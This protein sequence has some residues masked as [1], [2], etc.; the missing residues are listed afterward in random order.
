LSDRI[1][2]AMFRDR[3]AAEHAIATMRRAGVSDEAIAVL[4][5]DSE[6]L[7]RGEYSDDHR[8]DSKSSGA[9]KGLGVGAGVGALFGLSALVIP[10]VGPFI[11][12]G[13]LLETL[14]VIG[15][16]A[17]SGAIVGGTAGGIA[18]MLMKYGVPEADAHDYERQVREGGI[19]VGVDTR[20]TSAD[21]D[22][23]AGMLRNEGALAVGERHLH[24]T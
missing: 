14:G 9:F 5:R 6:H 12:A 20:R 18:G 13:S 17:A 21:R 3:D 7:E 23:I 22:L 15:S 11:A 1:V 16:A 8:V 24:S 19:W 10:G 2:S 4:G